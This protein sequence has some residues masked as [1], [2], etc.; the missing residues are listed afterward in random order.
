MPKRLHRILPLLVSLLLSGGIGY[1][2]FHK[3]HIA[4]TADT[5][6][7]DS[8]ATQSQKANHTPV[9]GTTDP[10]GK[11]AELHLFGKPPEKTPV[12][13]P[14]PIVTVAETTLDLV[15]HG[16]I[17]SGNT[18]FAIIADENGQQDTYSEGAK[19]P[20]GATITEVNNDY[21]V[22][23][24]DNRLET[25]CMWEAP[26]DEFAANG[27]AKFLPARVDPKSTKKTRRR[28]NRRRPR[29]R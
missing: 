16:I 19:L 21:V 13:T 11:I 15:L 9:K 4:T 24:N 25:L 2:L 8:I 23:L 10:S 6:T 27:A 5:S 18:S 26:Q 29:Q 22:L 20:G 17:A 3:F 1:T 28:I 14:I 7:T 12:P